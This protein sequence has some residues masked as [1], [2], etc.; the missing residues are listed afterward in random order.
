MQR[1]LT[2][3]NLFLL[4]TTSVLGLGLAATPVIL[5][6][7]LTSPALKAAWASGGGGGEGGE[8]GGGG[9][10]GEGGDGDSGGHGGDDSGEHGG[11]DG[12]HAESDDSHDFNEAGEFGE[13]HSPT[14]DDGPHKSDD[15]VN[16]Q[17][18]SKKL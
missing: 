11:N 17:L 10:G 2:R 18:K 1:K 16:A 8:G 14:D 3:R 15:K 5:D 6:L 7:D 4:A 13:S 12:D 9:G